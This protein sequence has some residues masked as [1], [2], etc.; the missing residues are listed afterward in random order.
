MSDFSF[1]MSDLNPI[2]PNPD[3]LNPD[4]DFINPNPV[5]IN[6]NSI[7]P[8]PSS[9]NVVRSKR[10]T[11]KTGNENKLVLKNIGVGSKVSLGVKKNSK[12][13]SGRNKNIAK[14]MEDIE[15]EGDDNE[16]MEVKDDE[17][18]VSEGDNEVTMNV[19]S[20]G[21]TGSSDGSNLEVNSQGKSNTDFVS[22]NV[23]GSDGPSTMSN[24]DEQVSGS[25]GV[26]KNV[27]L[28]SKGSGDMP[29]PFLE[30]PVLNPNYG[31]SGNV[32]S[33][34][35]VNELKNNGVKNSWPSLNESKSMNTKNA[36]SK[37]NMT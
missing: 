17:C 36:V 30:N 27:V 3:P 18:V 26:D 4:S 12:K 1:I 29:V 37:S 6:T 9:N 11:R 35:V 25:S 23:S 5:L 10:N 15:Y 33:P 22:L 20:Q 8:V 32:G 24:G 14:E 28:L 21:L 2:P 19:S 31:K 34:S 13:G 7:P 16:E